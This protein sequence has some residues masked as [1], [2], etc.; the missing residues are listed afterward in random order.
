MED[1]L[2][3]HRVE[4]LGSLAPYMD[5]EDCSFANGFLDCCT[6]EGEPGDLMDVAENPLWATVDEFTGPACIF[7]SPSLRYRAMD[8]EAYRAERVAELGDFI[9]NVIAGIYEG[10]R[11]SAYDAPSDYAR[12]AGRDHQS[13]RDYFASIMT[14]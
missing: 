1:L 9:G 13:W 12:A 5:E 11:A 14:K 7:L 4:W 2:A 8:V 6:V 3:Q 10:I